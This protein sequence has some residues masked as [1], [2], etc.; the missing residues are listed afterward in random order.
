LKKIILF[1]LLL[2]SIKT[3]CQ[4]AI[5]G[6]YY[7]RKQ[8]MVAGFNFSADGKFQFF[9]SYGAVDR[10]ATGTFAVKNDTLKLKSDKPPGNDFTISS[11]SKTGKGYTIKF[12]HSNPYLLKDILCVF[13]EAGLRKQAFSDEKGEVHI[14]LPHCDSI[15]VQHTLYPD[16][17]TLVKDKMNANNVFELTLNPSLE[18]VS[19]K[20]ID[21]KIASDKV[22]VCSPNYFM[23]MPDIEFVKE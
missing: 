6:E 15:F 21:F 10:S 11:Q 7:F 12:I 3:M 17:F 2:I 5:H 8:E 18:Q 1:F 14:D 22:I 20:G 19:F 4:S 23:E 9:Y 16:I 13:F